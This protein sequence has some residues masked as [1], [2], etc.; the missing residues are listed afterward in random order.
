[1][2][3]DV[4][5]DARSRGC[6]LG[7]LGL[8]SRPL[9]LLV[10]CIGLPASV[11]AQ[12]P[13]IRFEHVSID[14][15]LSQNTVYAIVQDR[16]GFLWIGTGDGLNR[17][18]GYSL[19]VLR[20]APN[21]LNSL[22]HNLI[23]AIF[24]DREGILWIGTGDGLNRYDRRTRTFT[25]YQH[26]PAVDGSLS[27]DLVSAIH[28]DR[29][30]VLWVG[31]AGGG[32]DRLEPGRS[33]SFIHLRNNPADPLSLSH[34]SVRSLF[35]DGQGNLWVG[36]Q[37]GL[38]RID[39]ATRRLTRYLP[40]AT[41]GA[42]GYNSISSILEDQQGRLWL[43]TWSG[44]MRFDPAKAA[45]D[46]FGDS[47][48]GKDPV[49]V[50]AL[51]QDRDGSLWLGT[52]GRGI[53]TFDP[54]KETF[55]SQVTHDP[56]QSSSLSGNNVTAFRRDRSGALWIGSSGDGLNKLDPAA[57][58]F[59]HYGRDPAAPQGLSDNMITAIH[60]DRAG[61]LWIGT[62]NA[63]LNRLDRRS[64][65]ASTRHSPPGVRTLRAD[66]RDAK[67][68]ARD[69]VR[70][71]V[72]DSAGT[73]W[74]GTEAGG[75]HRLEPDGSFTRFGHDPDDP[76]SLRD[77]DVWALHEDRRGT[78]WIGTYGGG[79]SRYDR[80]KNAFITYLHDPSDPGSLASNIVRAIYEDTRG[81]LWIGT[82][83]G[84]LDRFD[85]S[86]RSMG[87]PP[88]VFQHYRHD[89]GDSASLSSDQVLTILEDR[90]G[91]L[92]F[93]THGGGLNR[94]VPGTTDGP[95]NTSFRFYT[96]KDGLASDVVYG[97]L[98][99]EKG[100]LWMST[101]AGLSRF[102]PR[103]GSFRNYDVTDGLQS[104]EFNAGAYFKGRRGEMFFGGIDGFN[105]FFPAHIVDNPYV[106]PVVLTS[107][108]KFNREV[109]LES[110]PAFLSTVT[111]GPRE[112]V[113]SFEFAALSF[114][115]Q[116]KN[117]YAYRL[118][119]FRDQWTQ[120]GTKRDVTFTNLNPGAYTLEVRAANN[121]GVWNPRP[122]ALRVVVEP[123]FW[124]T[125][126]FA[127]AAGFAFVGML[128]GGYLFRT[129]TIR[130]NNRALQ[131]EI[132]ERL[133]VEKQLEANNKELEARNAEMERFVYTVSHDLKTPL[134]TIKGY[135]G[136][137]ERTA[138][139]AA[140]DPAAFQ[141]M[142]D[143]LGR[144]GRAA[145]TMRRLLEDLLH[146]SRVGRPM[147]APAV[148]AL[149][150]VAQEAAAL[151]TGAGD[152]SIAEMSIDPSMPPVKGDRMRLLEVY[153]NL[154]DNAIKFCGEGAT[155]RVEIGARQGP[156][157]VLCWVRDN[158]IG[159]DARYQEKVFGLFERLDQRI[160]GT[161]VGL[162]VVKRVVEAH[163]GR[164]WV[165]S[166]GVGRGSTFYFTLTPAQDLVA[167][168]E[169]AAS[170]SD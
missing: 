71:I 79:L 98:E 147:N 121:D 123:P 37:Q 115:A 59:A 44:L 93:G 104:R 14:H 4:I 85:P 24:E 120:L 143:D 64:E 130:R 156:E 161:G 134:V 117:Q 146:L 165:E 124:R 141:R 23:R 91:S 48:K 94:L 62:R 74:V 28:Q 33:G 137:L 2:T 113:F 127:S 140:A 129:R 131:A 84:G 1:M 135:V 51:E 170:G 20:S 169:S 151:V 11:A 106:P 58:A 95:A 5:L 32:L 102:D 126:W 110:E 6:C 42:G 40:D 132:V 78:L 16:L 116:R 41:A 43:G 82:G 160:S 29:A 36:T 55:V 63:G 77:N 45:F 96:Q 158:G 154:I 76:G 12:S 168:A 163:G 8:M 75:L 89:P 114:A 49:D 27:A 70:A 139:E 61:R 136:L 67:R 166:E 125:W 88:P 56:R 108:R 68:L 142:G 25:R 118:V 52:G 119:G 3:G 145:D 7:V 138:S 57:K 31:T 153:Q 157:Q 30:G 54:V 100:F 46:F 22:S 35:E 103:T 69:D 133:R 92:W 87:A 162:A 9:A 107:F 105:A 80:A 72:E 99:D 66:P 101:N 39:A 65:A 47:T 148:I 150:G 73:L 10:A 109:P 86:P 38:N 19:E 112:S 111:L 34:D 60:E 122:L 81:S 155:S 50:R 53:L 128:G 90:A 159:I 15:G 21:D 97:L 152:R 17:Y 167:A 164:I 149:S 144:I 13:E 26:D 83:G 18:D